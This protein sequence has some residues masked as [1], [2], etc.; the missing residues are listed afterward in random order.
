VSFTHYGIKHT[1]AHFQ[2]LGSTTSVG[3]AGLSPNA[4][5]DGSEFFFALWVGISGN[6]K[7]WKDLN[8]LLNADGAPLIQQK[9]WDA[10]TATIGW[11]PG[12]DAG[13]TGH[14]PSALWVFG[15]WTPLGAGGTNTTVSVTGSACSGGTNTLAPNN[16]VVYGTMQSTDDLNNAPSFSILSAAGSTVGNGAPT[17]ASGTTLSVPG[18]G[19]SLGGGLILGWAIGIDTISGVTAPPGVSV[20]GGGY[21]Q[22]TPGQE[23][24]VSTSPGHPMRLLPGYLP[25]GFVNPG[26]TWNVGTSGMQY[27]PVIVGGS[28]QS[29]VHSSGSMNEPPGV[30]EGAYQ[31]LVA[32]SSGLRPQPNYPALSKLNEPPGVGELAFRMIRQHGQDHTNP[33]Y[34]AGT[35]GGGVSAV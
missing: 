26:D 4:R 25:V 10:T 35:S 17:T 14:G 34:G 21:W 3:L 23:G 16:G 28:P 1:T 24:D 27:V 15:L 22:S 7:G 8:L 33:A 12:F 31:N 2:N 19:A 5:Q 30:G 11:G 6:T 9:F 20:S 32:S 29:D 18:G 13:P